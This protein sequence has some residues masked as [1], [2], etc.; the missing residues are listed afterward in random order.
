MS[1]PQLLIAAAVLIALAQLAVT[2]VGPDNIQRGCR[3]A[4]AWLFRRRA[5][6]QWRRLPR[7]VIP[8]PPPRGGRW[9]R[10]RDD[11]TLRGAW[12]KD[13]RLALARRRRRARGGMCVRIVSTQSNYSW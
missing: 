9:H 10:W 11:G 12:R 13:P 6:R 1:D 4:A 2:V 7:R 5:V 8:N 3:S